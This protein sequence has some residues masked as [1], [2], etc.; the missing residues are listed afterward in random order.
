MTP[1]QCRGCVI[2]E[3]S[4]QPESSSGRDGAG[5]IDLKSFPASPDE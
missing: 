4:P 5:A 2:L 1:L 3:Q